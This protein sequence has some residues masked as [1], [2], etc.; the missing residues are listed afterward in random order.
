M[1]KMAYEK[2]M[3]PISHSAATLQ[4]S[5]LQAASPIVLALME[6]DQELRDEAIGLFKE[7]ASGELDEGERFATTALLAEILFPIAD[8]QGLPGLDLAEA[9]ESAGAIDPEAQD[10]LAEMNQEEAIFADRLRD[11]MAKKGLTQAQLAAQ[12]GVG[13][14]A[15]SMMLQRDCRPQKRTVLRLAEVL[16]VQAEELWPKVKDRPNG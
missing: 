1:S 8:H 5:A 9:E 6:C 7:L 12:L 13:Q 4:A 16:G 2:T 10:V 11:L 15:I 3:A 14:P